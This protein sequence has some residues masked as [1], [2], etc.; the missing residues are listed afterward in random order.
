M[1]YIF[2]N[3]FVLDEAQVA[4]IRERLDRERATAVWAYAPGCFGPG[5][6][7]PALAER[8]TGI[9]L[10][11]DDGPAGSDGTGPLA[12]RS[13][14]TSYF[15]SPRMAAREDAGTTIE[16]LARYRDGGAAS[17]ARATVGAHTSVFIGEPSAPAAVLRPILAAAGAHI[18]SAGD[19]TLQTDGQRL[20][21]HAAADN[22]VTITPPEGVTLSAPDGEAIRQEGGAYIAPFGRGQTRWFNLN[23]AAAVATPW[24]EA[25]TLHD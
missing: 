23:P 15:F 18:W 4:A 21:I 1:E 24:G 25:Y 19:N 16:V 12:G 11:A 17:V 14:G 7:D 20:I 10:A 2:A 8:L 6:F 22:D 5:G 3:T 9:P 13:W